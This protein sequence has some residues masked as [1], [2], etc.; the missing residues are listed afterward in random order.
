MRWI[1]GVLL[2]L[3][4]SLGKAQAQETAAPNQALEAENAARAYD[5]AI[6]RFNTGLKDFP[7][8]QA[9]TALVLPSMAPGTLGK[10]YEYTGG[11]TQS[12]LVTIMPWRPLEDGH[13][14]KTTGGGWQQ[15]RDDRT[16]I[17]YRVNEKVGVLLRMEGVKPRFFF[18]PSPKICEF[19]L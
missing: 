3:A 11:A 5:Q 8:W 18:A 19:P 1:V 2:C 6:A 12:V 17:E 4:L 9:F 10:C 14:Q 7:S 15:V 16:F 13:W